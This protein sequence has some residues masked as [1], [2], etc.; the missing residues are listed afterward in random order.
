MLL[1]SDTEPAICELKNINIAR[2][3]IVA[4]RDIGKG[5]K[6]TKAKVAVKRPGNGIQPKDLGKILGHVTKCAIKADEV[7]T[8]GK[9]S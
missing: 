8:W 4:T 3:S 9:L 6:I 5:E 7:I 2:K 1:S